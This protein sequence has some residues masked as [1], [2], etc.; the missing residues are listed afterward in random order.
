MK[1]GILKGY[2]NGLY[3]QAEII[4]NKPI[5]KDYPLFK[6][7]NDRLD[8]IDKLKNDYTNFTTELVEI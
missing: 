7:H 1:Y 2:K 4:L 6:F 3:T 8:F 5:T